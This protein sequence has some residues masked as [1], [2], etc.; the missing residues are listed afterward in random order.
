SG[1]GI[2]SLLNSFSRKILLSSRRSLSRKSSR[3][4]V[5]LVEGL[6]FCFSEE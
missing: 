2:S 1:D 6:R 5:L 3:V 4:C